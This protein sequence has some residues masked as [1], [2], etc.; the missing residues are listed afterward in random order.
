MVHRQR[1]NE[2]ELQGDRTI[3]TARLRAM[4]YRAHQILN[5]LTA[6][7]GYAQIALTSEPSSRRERELTKIV[8]AVNRASREVLS[9][10]ATIGDVE[11][12]PVTEREM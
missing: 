1:D 4:R 5:Q 3:T 8:Q 2:L 7:S 9:C 12:G 6:I 11:K 10:L